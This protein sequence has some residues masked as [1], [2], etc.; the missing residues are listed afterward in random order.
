MVWLKSRV[1]RVERPES[2]T[3]R[4]KPSFDWQRSPQGWVSH[5]ADRDD[6]VVSRFLP[7]SD[8]QTRP[9]A[10]SIPAQLS[11]YLDQPDLRGGALS[12]ERR[13]H[14]STGQAGYLPT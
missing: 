3:T 8:P 6:D 5:T 2:G 11:S 13:L 9:F 7:A 12:F 1:G 10:C 14:R 4:G